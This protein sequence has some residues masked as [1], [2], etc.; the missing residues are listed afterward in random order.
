MLIFHGWRTLLAIPL[1]LVT[2]AVG[3]GI[4]T[5]L[6]VGILVGGLA[7][8]AMGLY[9]NRSIP[10]EDPAT[11]AQITRKSRFGFFFVPLQYWGIIIPIFA[12]VMMIVYG[13]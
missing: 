4:T 7:I 11:G 2:A 6:G 8:G 10:G 3:S 5:N 12:I 9:I 1:F 13:K